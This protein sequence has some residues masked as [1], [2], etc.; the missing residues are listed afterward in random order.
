MFEKI[1][2]IDEKLIQSVT[3]LHNPIL[4]RI[5]LFMTFLGDAGKIWFLV[6][7]VNIFFRRSLYVGLS[8]CAGM[9]FTF[10]M[11]EIIIKRIVC[12]VRPCHKID[13]HMLILKKM[14]TFYSF[15]S[16][17]SATSFAMVTV[18]FLI[19]NPWFVSVAMLIVASGIAFSRFYLQAHYLTDVICGIVIGIVIAMISVRG[20][21]LILN[22]INPSLIK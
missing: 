2:S 20:V 12:R 1:K 6:I 5:M 15:P 11:A 17:H 7:A 21:Y 13:E 22:A 10:L 8:L 19:Y 4:N 16:S 3:R 18:S 14:P 9:G